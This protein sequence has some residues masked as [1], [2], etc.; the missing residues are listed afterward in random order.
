MVCPNCNKEMEDKTYWYYGI[1]DWDM[2]YPATAHDEYWCPDCRIKYING[3]WFVP[4][5][6]ERATYK[7]IKCVEFINRELRTNY[8]PLL[9]NK[10][11]KFIH[12]N[13]E[14]AKQSRAANF[15][16]WCEDNAD[17]LPEYF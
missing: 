14:D 7:Q 9:K 2:D 1:S 11:W 8:K 6:I 17:W 4:K 13:L 12:D 15:E 16:C 3:E 10:T 5:G